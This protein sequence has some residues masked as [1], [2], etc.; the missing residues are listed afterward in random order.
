M[1]QQS[2]VMYL[3]LKDLNGIEI[4]NNLVATLKGE[5]KSKSTVT[6]YVRKPSFSSLK[7]P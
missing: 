2:I 3:N 1:D 5:T 4:H 7:T 6:R